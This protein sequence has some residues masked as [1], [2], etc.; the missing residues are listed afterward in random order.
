[1]TSFCKVELPLRL[2]TF[3]GSS[4]E[5]VNRAFSQIKLGFFSTLIMYTFQRLL[6]CL[7]SIRRD[8]SRDAAEMSVVNHVIDQEKRKRGRKA[9]L[10]ATRDEETH[11]CSSPT[12]YS[13]GTSTDWLSRRRSDDKRWK[14]SRFQGK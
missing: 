5:K 3:V 11:T 7:V 12:T 9:I 13:M 4:V 8:L 6:G 10:L 14:R 1:M 2:S